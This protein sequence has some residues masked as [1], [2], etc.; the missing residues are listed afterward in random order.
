[1]GA[2]APVERDDRLR[3][4]GYWSLATVLAVFG[5]IDLIA[6]GAPFFAVGMAMLIFGRWRHD[7][8]VFIPGMASTIAFVAGFWLV[9]PWTC[10]RGSGMDPIT[11]CQHAFGIKVYGDESL[12]PSFM[13]AV[14]VALGTWFFVRR[15]VQRRS[16][17]RAPSRT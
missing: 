6:I 17:R 9:A 7:R 15:I 12:W 2:E 13:V 14:L 8:M 1:M 4:V 5:F 16:H 3:T 10:V 11:V